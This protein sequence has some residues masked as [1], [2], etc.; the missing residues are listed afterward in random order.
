MAVTQSATGRYGNATVNG[1]A[2]NIT[3]WTGKVHKEF[4]IATD[5]GNYDPTTKQLFRARAPGEVWIEG[6]IK[7]NYDF[8][9]TT[10]ANLTQKYLSDGPYPVV[11]GLSRTANWA[12]F[13]ADFD[14][15]T[16]T[17][18]VNGANMITFET[19]F[20]SNGTPTLY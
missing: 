10:D 9:G 14:D 17:V 11:L 18:T 6:T 15:L 20:V 12:S 7:G 19:P 8:S 16:I 4:A 5:S 13:N 3:D 2:L 1:V